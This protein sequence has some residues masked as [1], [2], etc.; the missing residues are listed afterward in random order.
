[1]QTSPLR[2]CSQHKH[3]HIRWLGW[4]H[5]IKHA[6]AKCQY[7]LQTAH[8]SN[9]YSQHPNSIHGATGDVDMSTHTP[10]ARAILLQSA[11]LGILHTC[12]H[13]RTI[14]R[15]RCRLPRQPKHCRP[16]Y[17][18]SAATPGLLYCRACAH[19]RPQDGARAGPSHQPRCG[20][21]RAPCTMLQY[22]S[23]T[24]QHKKHGRAGP[25]T[26]EHNDRLASRQTDLQ[27]RARPAT[28]HGEQQ[29]AAPNALMIPAEYTPP[30]RQHRSLGLHFIRSS[31]H[32]SSNVRPC[33][34]GDTTHCPCTSTPTALHTPPHDGIPSN[35]SALHKAII[36]NAPT[37]FG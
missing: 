34:A 2:T 1:M 12:P 33:A 35:A 17:D 24:H 9:M 15:H 8:P 18:P 22:I 27:N 20:K 5:K 7:I 31:T 37:T 28:A 13:I 3:T 26:A 10:A 36:I 23:G 29:Q 25:H 6:G 19:G 11:T 32:H 4:C 21:E 30:A 14:Q 16:P